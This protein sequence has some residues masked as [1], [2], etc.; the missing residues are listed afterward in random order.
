MLGI[1]AAAAERLSSMHSE[2]SSSP[3]NHLPPPDAATSS[4]N[5][6]SSSASHC[7]SGS[8]TASSCAPSKRPKLIL[9]E[10]TSDLQDDLE[11][12][13]GKNANHGNIATLSTST[14]SSTASSSMKVPLS[15][16]KRPQWADYP[17]R[18][19]IG[20]PHP[21]DVCEYFYFEFRSL[22]SIFGFVG[23]VWFGLVWFGLFVIP[24]LLRFLFPFVKS[25]IPR[26]CLPTHS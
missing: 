2:A 19:I 20:P 23:W 16:A 7:P 3:K 18:D 6:D 22:S 25:C 17:L 14:A 10:L 13:S 12:T 5:N 24:L 1:M 21:H 4:L 15:I 26:R 8:A 11:S 9:P